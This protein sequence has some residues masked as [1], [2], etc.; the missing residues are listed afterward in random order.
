MRAVPLSQIGPVCFCLAVLTAG[1][2]TTREQPELA[3]TMTNGGPGKYGQAAGKPDTK[4]ESVS[5]ANLFSGKRETKVSPQTRLA[6]AQYLESHGNEAGARKDFEGQRSSYDAARKSYQQVL[7]ADEKSID[8]VIG[9]ARLDEVAGRTADAEQ[10]FL[11]AVRLDGN[12]PRSLDALGQFYTNQKRWAESTATLQ[13]ALAASPDDKAIQFHYGIALARSGQFDQAESYLANAVGPASAHYNLGVILHDH[14]EL[15]AAEQHFETALSLNPHLEQAQSW[16][17]D[18]RRE[19]QESPE[20]ATAAR[21]VPQRPVN[22]AA[23]RPGHSAARA[24]P[25]QAES[26]SGLKQASANV[27][28]APAAPQPVSRAE[29]FR[30]QSVDRR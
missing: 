26:P 27:P 17:S 8:A 14:G 29:L 3:G 10:G 4:V 24:V 28:A 7:A 1:C 16:L 15:N 5:L 2:V 23:A 13:R 30:Q 19:K 18:V 21:T 20:R 9:L 22:T 11:K 25:N 12:S 6:Y